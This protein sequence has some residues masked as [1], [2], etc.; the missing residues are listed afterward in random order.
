MPRLISSLQ[1]LLEIRL[2]ELGKKTTYWL[3]EE[4]PCPR[5]PLSEIMRGKRAIP[6]KSLHRWIRAL[7]YE[8]GSVEAKA[9]ETANR[10]LKAELK[11]DSGGSVREMR[12]RMVRLEKEVERLKWLLSKRDSEVSKIRDEQA[13]TAQQ[14]RAVEKLLSAA[15]R[16]LS[17]LRGGSQAHPQH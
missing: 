14:L 13:A 3:S 16:E 15:E 10:E 7:Q 12:A 5:G 8:A 1:H 4:I 17:R 11:K 6:V 2:E 9:L